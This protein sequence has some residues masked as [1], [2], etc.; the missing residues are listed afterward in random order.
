MTKREK[1]INYLIEGGMRPDMLRLYETKK[2]P[3]SGTIVLGGILKEDWVK[4]YFDLYMHI[5]YQE[6][7]I[8]IH[9]IRDHLK[10]Q[11][12]YYRI[13]WTGD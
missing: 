9:D 10:V 5:P 1:I 3:K 6:R 7:K 13:Y 2:W 4:L 11:Y 12:G 8:D